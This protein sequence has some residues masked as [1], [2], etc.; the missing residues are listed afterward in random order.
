MP[1]ITDQ[2][3]T[4]ERI[5]VWRVYRGMTQEACAGLVGKSLSWWKKVEAGVRRVEKL[6]D[7]VLIAQ[8][9]KVKNLADLTGS[10]EFSLNLDRAREI[11][12]LPPVRD[13]IRRATLAIDRPPPDPLRARIDDTR[14]AFH[15]DQRF[16]TKVG[17]DLPGLILDATARHRTE[18]TPSA[19]LELSDT[20]L[21]ACQWL[22]HV[23]ATD[24]ALTAIDRASTYAHLAGDPTAT[25]LAGWQMSGA[26]KD[27]GRAEEAFEVVASA[28]EELGRWL[29]DSPTHT[30]AVWGHLHLQ[31]ALMAAHCQDEGTA[32]RY[33]DRAVE[34]AATLPQG[35]TEPRTVFNTLHVGIFR[36]WINV[37]LGKNAKAVDAANRVDVMAAP[38]APVRSLGL[39]NVARGYAGRH[40]DVATFYI[41]KSAETES[42][43]TIAQSGHA[44]EMCREMM[45]RDR[46]SISRD[47]HDMAERIGLFA[48]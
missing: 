36:V 2:M 24:M 47:L 43:E 18:G 12:L 15:N 16:V 23:S 19:A 31:A 41:L 32:W 8:V 35:Y 46:K 34:V 20:Y 44:R 30:R 29:D 13:A 38:S 33:W 40:D 1:N 7:L 5:A 25:A 14:A 21:L 39:L 37:A 6:S 27:Q 28:S 11:E 48:E 10:L 26:M 9:L 42:P 45:R 22:R 4:G 17:R 3:S